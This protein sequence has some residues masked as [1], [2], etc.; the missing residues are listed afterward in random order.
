MKRAIL[1]GIVVRCICFG[2]CHINSF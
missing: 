2:L 1:Y